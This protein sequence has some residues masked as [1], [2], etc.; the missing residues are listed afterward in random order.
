MSKR[1]HT[2]RTRYPKAKPWLVTVNQAHPAPSMTRLCQ[3]L[4][5]IAVDAKRHGLT[6]T[7]V[8]AIPAPRV[9]AINPEA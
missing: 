3:E 1:H 8:S 6:P 2:T 7:T 4:M 9:Y 5:R